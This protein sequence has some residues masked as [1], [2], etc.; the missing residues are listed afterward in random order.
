VTN[1]GD[2]A[3]T[4][5]KIQVTGD[6][7]VTNLCGTSLPGHSTC[8]LQVVYSPKALGAERGQMT[9]QDGLGAQ[10]VT[11]SG[12]GVPPASGSGAAAALSPL[13]IDFGTQ[14]VNSISS[15][16]TLTLINTGTNALSGISVAASQQFA[17]A[18]NACTVTIAPGASCTVGVTFAPQATGT[19]EGT[20]QVTANG[21]STPFNVPV[22][23]NG[24]D[25][26]L[27]VQ[28][29]SSSTV[30]GGTSATY[31]LLLT[32][33]GTSTGQVSFTCTGAPGASTCST[34]PSNVTMT[35]TGA[36]STIQVTVNTSATSA[37]SKPAMP[38]SKP[39][40]GVLLACLM[41]WRRREWGRS[42]EPLCV[43]LVL[44]L[45]CVGLSGCGLSIKGGGAA[46]PGQGDGGS[47]GVYTIMVEAGAP[48]VSRSVALKL[49]VE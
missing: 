7:S 33:V 19:Q 47:Q 41:L 32:P 26:Q 10:V 35:G 18:N 8:A 45:I 21:V 43:L 16:Q 37:H 13:T 38:W 5:I 12:T 27:S 24:S 4:N 25:F 31:Q 44:G 20:V 1:S 14:G 22:T 30:T 3:L 40:A 15:P 2:S 9:I 29:A 6:F 46:P 23:G 17:I 49:T 36:T 48:G 11:L 28:G 34:N 39:S 42:F